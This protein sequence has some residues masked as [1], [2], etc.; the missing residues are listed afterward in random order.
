M[1]TPEGMIAI[2]SGSAATSAAVS[3]RF[4]P[5]SAGQCVYFSFSS[6]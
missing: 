5:A 3:R 4:V 1:S 6:G 2:T